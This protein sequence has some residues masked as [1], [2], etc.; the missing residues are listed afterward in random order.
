[1]KKQ[2]IW[3]TLQSALFGAGF[4]LLLFAIGLSDPKKT[5]IC[6]IAGVLSILPVSIG[7]IREKVKSEK[8]KKYTPHEKRINL[9]GYTTAVC[10]ISFYV[11]LI[12]MKVLNGFDFEIPDWI[13]LIWFLLMCTA[14]LSAGL[15]DYLINQPKKK[16]A[17]SPSPVVAQEAKTSAIK[18]TESAVQKKTPVK[19]EAT[20]NPQ[21]EKLVLD[22]RQNPSYGG[23]ELYDLSLVVTDKG[24]CLQWS[25]T[26]R[27]GYSHADAAGDRIP[28]PEEILNKADPEALILWMKSGVL[29]SPSDLINW[30]K[31]EQDQRIG[32]WLRSLPYYT[33]DKAAEIQKKL[34][35]LLPE[36]WS[37]ASFDVTVRWKKETGYELVFYPERQNPKVIL[38]AK[39]EKQ[40]LDRALCSLAMRKPNGLLEIIRYFTPFAR[41][42]VAG[43]GEH[44]HERLYLQ[45]MDNGEYLLWYTWEE[46]ETIPELKVVGQVC[47][48][49]MISQTTR[50]EYTRTEFLQASGIENKWNQWAVSILKTD[51]RFEE[52]FRSEPK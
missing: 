16:K 31:V 41:H 4:L 34:E 37:F 48:Y 2:K 38:R 35:K 25:V 11:M 5:L 23:A 3:N 32:P 44:G 21:I 17:P 50:K 28:I 7:L 45:S 30:D 24:P 49:Q 39:D 40:F 36:G 46:F 43:R 29:S 19:Q 10:G 22:G 8:N 20:H 12:V 18:K 9:L 42:D 15:R 27:G 47:E 51:S 6:F 14:L 26:W 52:L 13:G 1:M 33:T